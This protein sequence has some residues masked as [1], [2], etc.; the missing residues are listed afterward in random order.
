MVRRRRETA[1]RR[2]YRRHRI[3]DRD[4]LVA[5]GLRVHFGAAE[6]RQDQRGPAGHH[7]RAVEL[8]GHLHGQRAGA[9]R[10][11]GDLGVRR[12][13]GEVAADRHEHADA[14]RRASHGSSR[15]CR[16]PR[17]GGGVNDSSSPSLPSTAAARAR[18]PSSGHPAHWSVRAPGTGRRRACRSCR[19]AA[20]RW[21][22]PGS[23]RPSRAAG[24]GP[25]PSTRWWRRS[26][27]TSCAAAVISS[28]VSPVAASDV[29]PVER[30]RARP[31]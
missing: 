26:R 28:R 1:A 10:G 30:A 13:G 16:S 25:S 8:R 29:V 14:C 24:S 27:R 18:R 7:V 15:P 22:S 17:S 9:E 5:A 3:L 23:P 4:E 19:G 31:A 12:R 20:G 2:V 6:A 21:R 11:L